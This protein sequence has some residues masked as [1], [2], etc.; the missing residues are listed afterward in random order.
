MCILWISMSLVLGFIVG[1]QYEL[2]K[3]RKSDKDEQVAPPTP[4]KRTR[5]TVPRYNFGNPMDPII[6]EPTLRP[7]AELED[8]EKTEVED[9]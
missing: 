2:D 6:P 9:E 8:V 4:Y 7:L 1:R 3:A 5:P